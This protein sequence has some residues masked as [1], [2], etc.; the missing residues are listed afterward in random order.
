[1]KHGAAYRV[2]AFAPPLGRHTAPS[3]VTVAYY[4]YT[5]DEAL[6]WA[7][8]GRLSGTVTPSRMWVQ[9]AGQSATRPRR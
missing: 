2:M 5:L 8:R 6:T 1:M 4:A 7:T 9:R 3:I